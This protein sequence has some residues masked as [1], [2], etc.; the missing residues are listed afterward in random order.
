MLILTQIEFVFPTAVG[1]NRRRWQRCGEQQGSR[2]PQANSRRTCRSCGR[3]YI[4]GVLFRHVVYADVKKDIDI[5]FTF[6]DLYLPDILPIIYLVLDIHI[7]LSLVSQR[8]YLDEYLSGNQSNPHIEFK[9]SPCFFSDFSPKANILLLRFAKYKK[10]PKTMYAWPL[11]ML[12][13]SNCL[14]F[15][16]T[17]AMYQDFV[18]FW[19]AGTLPLTY[20]LCCVSTMWFAFSYR[21][22]PIL[23]RRATNQQRW[24]FYNCFLEIL[25]YNKKP[26]QK[27]H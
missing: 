10:T 25:G 4:A 27:T 8:F 17:Q 6:H 2:C 5:I 18:L 15:F 14:F 7:L 3:S 1:S 13:S 24:V 9:S 11:Y 21:H 26:P 20:I 23:Q 22:E 16:L 19:R 12:T